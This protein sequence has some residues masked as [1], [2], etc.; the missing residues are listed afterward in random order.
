ML[1]YLAEK[2][3]KIY[4]IVMLIGPLVSDLPIGDVFRETKYSE[5]FT[6]VFAAYPI[7]TLFYLSDKGGNCERIEW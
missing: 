1:F 3:G 7:Y 5:L 2:D 4:I 6:Y